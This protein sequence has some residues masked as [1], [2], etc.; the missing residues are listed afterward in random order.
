M[1]S[2]KTVDGTIL[3]CDS[4]IKGNAYPFLHINTGISMQDAI[5]IFTPENAETLIA[6]DGKRP[7]REYHG[8]T[9]IVSIQRSPLFQGDILIMLQ[10]PQNYAD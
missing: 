9:E 8:F 4:V 1:V 6:S 10:R 3:E 7:D 2:L 5:Q